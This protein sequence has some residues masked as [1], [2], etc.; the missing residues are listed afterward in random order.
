M[1][2]RNK[3]H[4]GGGRNEPIV[5]HYA[6]LPLHLKEC[7][8]NLL[9]FLLVSPLHLDKLPAHV[10]QEGVNVLR[11]ALE[12]L[13]KLIVLLLQLALDVCGWSRGSRS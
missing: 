12:S 6:R 3:G 5:L 8:L 4:T 10:L 9:E 7:V 1:S 2:W 13:D 11:L